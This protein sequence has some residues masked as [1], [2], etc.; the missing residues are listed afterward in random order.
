V[1][2]GAPGAPGEAVLVNNVIQGGSGPDRSVGVRVSGGVARVVYNVVMGGQGAESSAVVVE[3]ALPGDVSHA[4]VIDSVLGMGNGADRAGLRLSLTEGSAT[5]VANDF[6][7]VPAPTGWCRVLDG[8]LCVQPLEVLNDCE[9]WPSCLGADLNFSAPPGFV[10]PPV[11]YHLAPDSL[12]IDA[13]T[14]PE[15]W[16]DEPVPS[17]DYDLDP[18][19]LGADYDVGIDE[20]VVSE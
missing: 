4:Y 3:E 1:Q 14:D 10:A 6:L 17:F 2:V 15:P 20:V 19:P 5:A 11:D 9:A 12:L 13:G 8:A 18:R 7:P 16:L